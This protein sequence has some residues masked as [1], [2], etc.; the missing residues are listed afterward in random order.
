[1]KWLY[2]SVAKHIWNEDRT[3][4]RSFTPLISGGLSFAVL[5]MIN[6]KLF[7]IFDSQLTASIPRS[8]AVAFLVGF[9]SDNTIAKLAEIA[10]SIFGTTRPKPVDPPKHYTPKTLPPQ[11]TTEDLSQ[12]QNGHPEESEKRIN[13]SR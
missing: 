9:F 11:N 10:E 1:M 3:L 8:A 12:P 13:N 4:W 6:S 5:A 2:H 7:G